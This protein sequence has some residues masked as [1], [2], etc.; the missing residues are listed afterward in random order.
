MWPPVEM[1]VWT[2]RRDA[3]DGAAALRCH[4]VVRAWD[5][6]ALA[7]AP[8]LLGFACDEGVRRN[9]GR[10]GA[11]AGPRALRAALANMA[12][13][14]GQPFFDA[15]DIACTG[16][17]LEAA[18]QA[19]GARVAGVLDAGGFALVAGGGH[20]LAWGSF[21]GVVRHLG[22]GAPGM[23]IGVLNVDAHFDLRDARGGANS[24]TPFRQVADWCEANGAPFRYCVLGVSPAANTPALYAAARARGAQWR[25]D[26]DCRWSEL[27]AL[28]ALIEGFVRSV[29]VL[30]LSVCLDAFPAASAPGVSAPAAPGVDP[31]LAIVLLRHAAA[32]CRASGTRWLVG[33]IAELNPR[34][35]S[36]GRT[37]RLAARLAHEMLVLARPATE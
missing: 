29:D 9:Q 18:Q 20:E 5:G 25:E 13:P 22:D 17:A 21:A 12:A 31:A 35:D 37:A 15:G 1:D 28:R 30:Q 4:Q 7:G 10:V 6:E 2:G 19:L 33:E 23:R 3:A 27:P 16:G 8:A 36:D 11:A 34:F 26:I 14:A 32:A 24:G